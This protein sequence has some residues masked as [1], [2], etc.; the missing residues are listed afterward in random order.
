LYSEFYAPLAGFFSNTY[1]IIVLDQNY[2]P[3]LVGLE[4]GT[5]VAGILELL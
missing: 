2:L 1:Q 3:V 4:S 5:A